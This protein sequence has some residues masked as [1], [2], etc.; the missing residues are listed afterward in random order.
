[1]T[2]GNSLPTGEQATGQLQPD[3]V[4]ITGFQGP[5]TTLAYGA[6]GGRNGQ[7]ELR[8][9]DTLLL[10]RRP[11]FSYPSALLMANVHAERTQYHPGA[12]SDRRGRPRQTAAA[13]FVREDQRPE[14]PQ[15]AGGRGRHRPRHGQPDRRARAAGDRKAL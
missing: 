2:G 3:W 11:T 5:I 14:V 9:R 10:T 4:Q 7:T 6:P 15:T 13:L 8:R 1:M 12:L